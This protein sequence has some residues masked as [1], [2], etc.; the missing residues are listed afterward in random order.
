MLKCLARNLIKKIIMTIPYSAGFDLCWTNYV[1]TINEENLNIVVDENLKNL[2]KIFYNFVKKEMQDRNLYVKNTG[3][4]LKKINE[5]FEEERKYIL[6]GETGFADISYYKMR[7]SSLDKKYKV[8]GKFKRVTK[9]VLEV[10]SAID[11]KAF[12]TASGANIAHFLDADEIRDVELRLGYSVIT[13]HDS[14][15]IDFLNCS[16]LI[17][18]R[19]EHYRF[20]LRKQ[21]DHVIA[22]IYNLI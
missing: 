13:I 5:N 19:L 9:L 12:N 3:T 22:N 16:N 6:E 11:I 14:Y 10:T 20:Y 21:G 4:F 18:V 15:L 8:N 7:K 17:E 1:H 2:I